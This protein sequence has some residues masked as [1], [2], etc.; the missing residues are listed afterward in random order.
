MR[1]LV[2]IP[3]TNAQKHRLSRYSNDVEYI[4][5]ADVQPHDVADKE[6]IIGNI[7]KELI[8][9]AKNLKW[10]QLSM[11][12][13]EGYPERMPEGAALTNSRGAFGLAISEHMLGML[14]MLKKRLHQ[15]HENQKKALWQPMGTVTSVFESTVLIVGLGNIGL[16]FAKRVKALGAYT[17]GIKR[18]IS[19]KPECIDEIYTLDKLD[20]LIPRA[21]VIAL[22]VPNNPDT[23]KLMNEKRI[24][25]MKQGAV[26]LN[27][28][29]G[30]LVDTDALNKALSEGRIMAGLDVTDPEPLPDSHPLWK[31]ENCIITPH[32]SGFFYLPKTLEYIVEI[33]LDNMARYA[34]GKQLNNIIKS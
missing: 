5:M 22:T 28:G 9:H 24:Y 14:L 31:Q 34:E 11:S 12:G 26:L 18:D 29:R 25:L 19:N 15:Y 16:E 17:I 4:K 23:Y 27:V 1:V 13:Y 8:Q 32:I 33:A 2:T 3:F 20:E 10:L 21:D 7:P 30:V 6:V